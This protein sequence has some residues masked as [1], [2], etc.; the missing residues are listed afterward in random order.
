MKFVNKIMHQFLEQLL[1]NV[2]RHNWH[3][4]CHYYYRYLWWAT[5]LYLLWST[6]KIKLTVKIPNTIQGVGFCISLHLVCHFN[7]CRDKSFS[8][9]CFITICAIVHFSAV[10]SNMYQI[11]FYCV[12]LFSCLTNQC[13][14]LLNVLYAKQQ[15]AFINI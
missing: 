3:C 6:Y 13:V 14:A 8:N 2:H 5:R 4:H 11:C 15:L 10:L 1:F 9:L 12:A 7:L